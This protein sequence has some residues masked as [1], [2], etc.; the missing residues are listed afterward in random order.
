M[1]AKSL[2]MEQ[3]K[4]R[5]KLQTVI[6]HL[7]TKLRE[8]QERIQDD[9]RQNDSLRKTISRLVNEKR[10]LEDKLKFKGIFIQTCKHLYI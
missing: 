1:L 2:A 8:L 3:W 10:V 7:K 9:D 6:E 5:K 4:E